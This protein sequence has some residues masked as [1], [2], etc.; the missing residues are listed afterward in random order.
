MGK[1]LNY[2]GGWGDF[3]V[4]GVI[5]DMPEN[6]HIRFDAMVPIKD[7]AP[8]KEV[9]EN[10]WEPLFFYS[11]VQLAPNSSAAS[12]APKIAAIMN[13][14]I[15]NLRA[16]V[17]LQ[18]LMD[19][20]L[21]SNF[22]WDLDNYAQGSQSTL[23]IFTLAAIGVLLLAMINFMNLSTA[24]SAN[25]SKEVGLR[26]VIG[27][28]RTEVMGQF[29]GESVLLAFL[30]LILALILVC[31]GLPLFNNLAGKAIAF[32]GLFA[33]PLILSLIGMTLLT[34]L[35]SGSYPSFFLS[36]FQ[37]SRV[38]KGGVASG[39]RSQAAL[40]KTLVVLQFALTLFFVMGTAVVDR[41]LKFIREKNLG[42]DTHNVVATSAFFRD[43]QSV[44]NTLLSNPNVLSVTRSDPP[45]M[46][47]RGIPDVAW[48]GKN[49]GDEAQFFPVTVDADYLQTFHVGLAEGRFFS[50]EFPSDATE[51]LVLNE[52][53]VR[54]M[55]MTSPVGKK[56]TIGRQAYTV[57]G[58]VKDFH[59]S[60]LH[61][62]IEPM[63]LRAPPDHFLMCVRISPT[64]VQDTI[65]FLETTSKNFSRVPDFIFRHEFLDDRI[66]GFYSSERKV[67]AILGL[68]T[69]IA[70]FTACLGLFGLAS[71]LAERRT[72][73]IGIRK[74]L[75][76]PVSGLILLQTR[77]FSK[78][79]LLSGLVAGPAAYYAT[80]RWLRGFAYH[81]NPSVGVF[82][83]AVF[84]T[85]LIALLAVGFQAVRAARANPVTSLRYE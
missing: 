15:P 83:S 33:P 43:Y 38:L 7:I 75:G 57:I 52:T 13:E 51:S 40:R 11:Y 21:K 74:I 44:K 32:S 55:G 28:R 29:L 60:S 49:P 78:W 79:V 18:P 65:A 53:A 4:T 61:R 35:L 12:A 16:D 71:F 41:Q 67:E 82:L 48:E 1:I 73:E 26:K 59:Q 84:A 9:G 19:V 81:T 69:A 45:Q 63:I 76:A 22:Q 5:R 14:N 77:E 80:G 66:D 58:V 56:V 30:G 8:G 70:L 37:P 31:L 3:K 64:N 42:I 39:G 36:A 10:D 68:F 27:A 23:T 62:P 25:R 20:H 24:R 46:E 47:Q 6:S 2:V 72:K 85:L 17:L 54:A 50:S 34:G